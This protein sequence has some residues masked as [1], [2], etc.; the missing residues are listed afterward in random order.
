MLNRKKCPNCQEKVKNNSNFCPECGIN[1]KNSS[2][3]D[4][5][6]LG[7]KDSGSQQEMPNL[8]GGIGGKMMNKMLGNAMKML[9]KEMMKGSTQ[10][11]GIR[12]MINGKEINP[13]QAIQKKDPNTKVLPIE[14]SNENLKRWSKLKKKEPQTD[15]KRIDEKIKYSLKIPGVESIK[16]ISIIKLESGIE[17]KAVSEKDAYLKKIPINLPL[18]KY[19]LL[20]GVLTLEL[21]AN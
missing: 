14:L 3:S 2:P 16:D 11:P 6:M 13:N 21:E 20:N 1:L 4:W 15:I 9:E 10:G 18:T 17:V 12:L 8:F 7:K 5:G 19:S